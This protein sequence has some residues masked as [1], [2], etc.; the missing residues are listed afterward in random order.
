MTLKCQ[1]FYQLLNYNE[2]AVFSDA[3]Q[4]HIRARRLETTQQE[5]LT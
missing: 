1:E 2:L 3:Q 5:T 4:A